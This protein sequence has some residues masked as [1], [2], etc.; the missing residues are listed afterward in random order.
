MLYFK[1]HKSQNERMEVSEMNLEGFGNLRIHHQP[2]ETDRKLV[3][4]MRCCYG[5]TGNEDVM[6]R[7]DLSF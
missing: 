2:S 4:R 7:T 1:N 3:A 6:S 5:E